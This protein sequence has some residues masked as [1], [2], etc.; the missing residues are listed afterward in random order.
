MILSRDCNVLMFLSGSPEKRIRNRAI[1]GD[2]LVDADRSSKAP[3]ENAQRPLPRKKT[4][5]TPTIEEADASQVTAKTASNAETTYLK[6]G[7]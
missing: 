3:S 5:I 6:R 7:S 1:W 2:G 4:W